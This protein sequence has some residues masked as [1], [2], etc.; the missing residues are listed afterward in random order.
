MPGICGVIEVAT[1]NAASGPAAHDLLSR[2]VDELRRGPTGQRLLHRIDEG[3]F[4]LAV[5]GNGLPSH[6]VFVEPHGTRPRELW[7]GEVYEGRASKP[8]E[9]AGAQADRQRRFEVGL[10]GP[11]MLARACGCFVG[12]HWDPAEG[13]YGL[14]TDRLGS[15]PICFRRAGPYLLFAPETKALVLHEPADLDA[16]AGA[17]AFFLAAGCLPPGRTHF[18]QVRRLPPAGL[19]SGRLASA[20][21]TDPPRTTRYWRYAFHDAQYS[22]RG[23]SAHARELTDCLRET[24]ARQIFPGERV[25]VCLSGGV[26]SRTILG[27][28]LERSARVEAVTWGFDLGRPR[29]DV[30]IARRIAS[31]A[32]LRHH[33]FE[34]DPSALPSNA[35]AWVWHTDGAI[36]GLYNYPQGLRVFA[37]IAREHDVLFRGEQSFLRWPYGVPDETTAKAAI[38]LHPL[39][40][41]GFWFDV[42]QEEAWVALDAADRVVHEEIARDLQSR[43]PQDRKD[44]YVYAV[45]HHCKMNL[46]N[47]FK[48]QALPVRSPL[49]DPAVLELYR[50]LPRR[51]RKGKRLFHAAM[52]PLIARFADIPWAVHTNLIPW[53]RLL[54]ELSALAAYVRDT[55]LAPSLE[56]AP[57]FDRGML[58]AEIGRWLGASAS[59]RRAPAWAWP[60]TLAKRVVYSPVTP[61]AVR[62]RVLPERDGR[63][64]QSYLF[65]LLVLAHY[66][67]ELRARGVRLDWAAMMLH[68]IARDRQ[69]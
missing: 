30:D 53:E 31:A 40:W 10:A 7:Y 16:D 27:L 24:M 11:A 36:D 39:R 14:F 61:S 66:C 54:G 8:T 28:A 69:P 68:G 3:G 41:H 12:I 51:Y 18:A 44:E 65:R 20:G 35:A 17:L 42:L 25:G 21:G 23:E 4:H 57:L 9:Q 22:D 67:E 47:Y 45:H 19:L 33:V 50:R 52:R 49:L 37:E 56:L 6:C 38:S 26:D 34:L 64:R 5:V 46:L 62:G 48:M 32:G 55:L 58:E 15:I 43:H 29:A 13:S 2:M 59:S 1:G 63:R 60:R